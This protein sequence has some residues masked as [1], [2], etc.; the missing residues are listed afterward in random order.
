MAHTTVL[1]MKESFK[2][3]AMIYLNYSNLDGETQE[4]L[5]RRSKNDIE[6]KYGKELEV[7]ALKNQLDYN[8]LLEEEAQRN[9]Y[10]YTFRFNSLEGIH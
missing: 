4:R 9:L 10:Q 1:R 6:E 2:I 5:M 8:T 3:Q 7:Y